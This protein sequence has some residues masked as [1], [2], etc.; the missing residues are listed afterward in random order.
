MLHYDKDGE[1]ID[2]KEFDESEPTYCICPD[3][4]EEST[5]IAIDDGYGLTEAW[6]V[7]NLHEDWVRV[8]NCCKAEIDDSDLL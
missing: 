7:T 8:S 4:Q 6:G 2:E 5:V 3:C 1:R